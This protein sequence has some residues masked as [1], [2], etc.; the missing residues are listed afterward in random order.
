MD[1]SVSSSERSIA[2]RRR[3]SASVSIMRGNLR[4]VCSSSALP[5][6]G[7]YKMINTMSTTYKRTQ[8]NKSN[9]TNRE[10]DTKKMKSVRVFN[11]AS[12]ASRSSSG[13]RTIPS[14]CSSRSR[15]SCAALWWF[16]RKKVRSGG[17]ISHNIEAEK[18][19]TRTKQSGVDAKN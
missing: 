3:C 1:L 9:P 15:C 5:A 14:M 2:V 18:M 10:T 6:H 17:N 7:A 11:A 16:Q 19:T 13:S 4:S 12:V 8:M